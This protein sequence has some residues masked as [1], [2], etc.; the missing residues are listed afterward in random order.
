[1]LENINIINNIRGMDVLENN[2]Y[3]CNFLDGGGLQIMTEIY[4]GNDILTGD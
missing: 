1:M 3:T 2:F 4:G